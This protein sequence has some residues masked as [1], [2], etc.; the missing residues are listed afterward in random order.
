MKVAAHYR[1]GLSY[2]EFHTEEF[3]M[4]GMNQLRT[5]GALPLLSIFSWERHSGSEIPRLALT[6]AD[7]KELQV[8]ENL[9]DFLFPEPA[10]KSFHP[11]PMETLSSKSWT[12]LPKVSSS[13]PLLSLSGSHLVKRWKHR[14]RGMKYSGWEEPPFE[15]ELPLKVGPA[16]SAC[17]GLCQTNPFSSASPCTSCAPAL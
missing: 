3:S 15:W 7:S 8:C 1:H 4:P 5:A 11:V 12:S 9:Q 13:A 14:K 2:L 16:R 6:Q 17:S 10:S